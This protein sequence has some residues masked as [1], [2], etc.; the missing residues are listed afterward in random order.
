MQYWGRLGIEIWKG[1]FQIGEPHSVS[2]MCY[3]YPIVLYFCLHIWSCSFY[4][5][6]YVLLLLYQV[7]LWCC[8]LTSPC[9]IGLVYPCFAYKKTHKSS[10]SWQIKKIMHIEVNTYLLYFLKYTYYNLSHMKFKTCKSHNLFL[11]CGIKKMVPHIS[12]GIKCEEL[13]FSLIK[14]WRMMKLKSLK[15]QWTLPKCY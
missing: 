4:L 6:I 12:Y 14:L 13:I 7:S 11:I 10:G 3:L 5:S 9:T 8:A 1:A 2:M 15:H